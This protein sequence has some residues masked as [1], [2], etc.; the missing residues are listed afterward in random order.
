M[1]LG[2]ITA[3]TQVTQVKKKERKKERSEQRHNE[4]DKQIKKK[5]KALEEAKCYFEISFSG[6][7][8]R[9]FTVVL[10]LQESTWVI[11]SATCVM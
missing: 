9:C 5:R 8:T 7:K 3:T 1:Q 11:E 6:E 2:H 10:R 4:A